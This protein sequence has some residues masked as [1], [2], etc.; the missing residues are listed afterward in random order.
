MKAIK[1]NMINETG[2]PHAARRVMVCEAC[3][4]EFS[5]NAGDYFNYPEDHVF[6]CG[7]CGCDQ[8]ELLYKRTIIEYADKPFVKEEPI[9]A[10]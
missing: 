1:S 7:N 5:A 4:S 10:T 2:L 6:K 3:D 8:M 9:E